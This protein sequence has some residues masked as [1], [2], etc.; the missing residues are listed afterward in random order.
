MTKEIQPSLNNVKTPFFLALV[1]FLLIS[2]SIKAATISGIVKDNNNEPIPSANIFVANLGYGTATNLK[3]EFSLELKEG[4]HQIVTSFLG[5][6][7]DTLLLHISSNEKKY[8]QIVLFPS[9]KMLS[10]VQVISD[11]RSKAKR[12]MKLARDKRE[13]FEKQVQDYVCT[14]YIKSSLT[15]EA[16][17]VEEIDTIINDS[18]EAE[19]KLQFNR[20]DNL[21]EYLSLTYYKNP[22]KL[23]QHFLAV[24]EN[25]NKDRSQGASVSFGFNERPNDFAPPNYSRL[26]PYMM[27]RDMGSCVFDFYQNLI[28]YPTLSNK[29]FLSP[30]ASGAAFSYQYDFEG[31]TYIDSSLVFIISVKPF[32]STEPLFYGNIYIQDSTWA[33]IAVDLAINPAGLNYCNRFHIK[34]DY[35]QVAE[36]VYLPV[37]RDLSYGI[38]LRKFTISGSAKVIHMDYKPNQELSSKE[39]GSEVITFDKKAFDR[40][41][42]FWTESRPIPLEVKELQ[43]LSEM[44]SLRNYYESAE[45]LRGIDSS[46]NKVN[47]WS[48][49]NGVGH[50]NRARGNEWYISGLMEQMVFFGIGGYRHRLPGYFIK[51]LKNQNK[52][53]FR[54]HVDYGFV[55]EDVKGRIGVGYNY[56]RKRFMRTFVEI[57]DD[58]SMINNFASVQ[59]IF[60]RSNFARTITFNVSQRLEVVNGLYA[61]FYYDFSDQS[62][63]NNLQLEEWS[64]QVFG[65]LNT[66]VDFE[67]Y[68]KSEM[69]LRFSYRHKQKYYYKKNRKII[70]GSSYPTIYMNY[71]KGVPGLFGS[72]VNFDYIELNAY[73]DKKIARW[74]T[75][76]WDVLVGSF[77]N[78]KSLRVLEHKY[79]RGSD[80]FFFSDPLYSFQLLGPTLSTDRDFYKLSGIH[81]FEG[82]ITDKIPYFN[83][84]KLHLAGGA[85]F[86]SI[87]SAGFAHGELFA[88]FERRFRI[89]SQIFRIGAY[90]VSVANTKQSAFVS[91]KFGISF[92]NPFT[93]SFDY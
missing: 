43:Y 25:E 42:S 92:F 2:S 88:G 74:G 63:I 66:P 33:L 24:N 6:S 1:F 55:N 69:R 67:R 64:G 77:F 4:S 81:H 40:D 68:I 12:I 83:R 23:K 26:N 22:D 29:P 11:S 48:F 39:F 86:I 18:I 36:N 61:E 62:A 57:G 59:Q 37:K 41:S 85:G 46:F 17:K 44:D 32:S 53:E 15:Y 82:A 13:Y 49:I 80:P 91:Y 8:L 10:E 50:R 52:V 21:I 31:S 9:S 75:L 45:Y 16:K 93:N 3:G 34:Q 89:R 38:N 73:D 76:R 27:Y 79:F 87:P 90:A 54:G 47:L 72:E 84:L 78:T 20:S 5:F 28:P 65:S 58:Y 7:S 35:S 56:S 30:L 70:V 71:R 19:S 14:T 60:S 51:T